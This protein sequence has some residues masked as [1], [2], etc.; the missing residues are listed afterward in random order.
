MI[1]NKQLSKQKEWAL[2][3]SV[4]SVSGLVMSN[5]EKTLVEEHF[6]RNIYEI[7]HN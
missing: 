4:R 1:D 6:F 7:L 2:M 3:L 5:P